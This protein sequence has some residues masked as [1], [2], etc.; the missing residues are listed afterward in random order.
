MTG[1]ALFGVEAGRGFSCA[2]EGTE[3]AAVEAVLERGAAFFG[4]G[5]DRAGAAAVSREADP[6][7]GVAREW[8][9]A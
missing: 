8:I 6:R 7:G 4:G 1:S 2:W 9:S 5:A 3:S